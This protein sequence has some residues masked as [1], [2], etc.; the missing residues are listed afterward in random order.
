[1]P[2][3]V[4]L[5]SFPLG[6]SFPVIALWIV[7]WFFFQKHSYAVLHC[8]SFILLLLCKYGIIILFCNH[9]CLLKH[10]S[11]TLAIG[12]EVCPPSL[13]FLNNY[14]GFHCLNFF[15]VRTVKNYWRKVDSYF[16]MPMS[17]LRVESVKARQQ[18]RTTNNLKMGKKKQW[19][20]SW[21]HRLSESCACWLRSG[22]QKK[23][24]HCQCW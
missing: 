16:F 3:H 12:T 5:K 11:W 6:S 1:M 21:G 19:Q 20:S 15:L 10:V 22:R 7:G 4:F 8:Y 13:S 17:H 14:M 9:H 2:N 23:E 24:W 18:S